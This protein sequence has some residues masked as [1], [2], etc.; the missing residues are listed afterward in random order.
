MSIKKSNKELL[1]QESITTD[2]ILRYCDYF[3]EESK[4]NMNILKNKPQQKKERKKEKTKKKATY[5]ESFKK[6]IP[7][8]VILIE[9]GFSNK[10]IMKKVKVS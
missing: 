5:K 3:E 9:E 8:I 2:D 4:A 7:I 6:F 1:F 10:A